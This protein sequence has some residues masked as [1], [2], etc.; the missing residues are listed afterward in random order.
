MLLLLAWFPSLWSLWGMLCRPAPAAGQFCYS[1]RSLAMSENDS[2]TGVIGTTPD[3]D[4]YEE[5][6]DL[7]R[8][9]GLQ[10]GRGS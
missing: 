9:V 2:D 6:M 1:P 4:E 3:C 8:T 5:Y 10:R 7:R